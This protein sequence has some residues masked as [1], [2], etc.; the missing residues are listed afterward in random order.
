MLLQYHIF[1]KL[2][3]NESAKQEVVREILSSSS[4]N[5]RE[6]FFVNE[7][8]ALSDSERVSILKLLNSQQQRR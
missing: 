5:T 4:K 1:S 7:I 3:H 2:D 8:N 6:E